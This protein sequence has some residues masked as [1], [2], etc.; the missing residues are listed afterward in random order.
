MI[1]CFK[2]VSYMNDANQCLA[3][4]VSI[5]AKNPGLGNNKN[6]MTTNWPSQKKAIS[7]AA[8]NTCHD[9]FNKSSDALYRDILSIYET[10]SELH[11]SH[12]L[13]S[14]HGLML[15]CALQSLYHRH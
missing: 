11:L 4:C 13:S 10:Q 6:V 3:S 12:V 14:V 2:S 7:L 15:Q 8:S 1:Y 5:Y 9:T